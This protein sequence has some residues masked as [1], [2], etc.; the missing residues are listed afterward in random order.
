MVGADRAAAAGS[1]VRQRVD[2]DRAALGEAAAASGAAQVGRVARGCRRRSVRSPRTLGK[3]PMSARVYGWAGAAEDR[4]RPA[5]CSAIRPAYMIDRAVAGLGDHRQVVADE[6]HRQA[7]A[8]SRR[9]P[10]EAE[11]LGLDHHVERGHRLVRDE[12]LGRQ[13]RAIAIITRWRIPPE[14]SCGYSRPRAGGMPDL[15]EQLVDAGLAPRRGRLRLVEPDRLDDLV[16]DRAAPG[17][18]RSSRPGRRPTPRRQRTCSISR[19][20]HGRAGRARRGGCCAAV[21]PASSGQEPGDREGRRGLAAA[22]L[23]G[24]AD[25]LAA[26]RRRG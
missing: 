9:S 14:N 13:A 12:E 20:G 15:L 2:R 3:A 23:A 19:L 17:S 10:E 1:S 21:D 4:R 16:A 18:A 5:P 7:R 22:G 8:R 6:D 24:E 25:H 11:D 26:L